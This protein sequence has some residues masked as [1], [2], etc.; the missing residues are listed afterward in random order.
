MKVEVVKILAIGCYKRFAWI[1]IT[2]DLLICI[3]I[4]NFT[5][6]V[7]RSNGVPTSQKLARVK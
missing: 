5:Y 6:K 4:S 3:H 2:D 1:K 7:L